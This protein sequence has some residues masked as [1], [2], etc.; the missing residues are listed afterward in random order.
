MLVASLILLNEE[1]YIIRCLESFSE[2][3]NKVILIDGGSGDNTKSILGS[4][5]LIDKFR[6]PFFFL[7]YKREKRSKF[8]IHEHGWDFDNPHMFLHQRNYMLDRVVEEYKAF[9]AT[10]PEDDFWLL[11]M[12]AD[13]CLSEGLFNFLKNKE[14]EALGRKGIEV[15]AF[16][17]RWWMP[18]ESVDEPELCFDDVNGGAY[19]KGTVDY[20]PRL[21]KFSPKFRYEDSIHE[22]IKPLVNVMKISDE[23]IY[24]IHKKERKRYDE[25]ME[26]YG[27][28]VSELNQE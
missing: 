10:N 22:V 16:V 12:D 15:I 19:P 14:Y 5:D 4:L 11:L 21:I 2:L 8:I 18:E 27:K 26:Y 28:I 25:Q 6:D 3:V 7:K 13:E 1:K 9:I 24:I 17:R 20:Q 23:G